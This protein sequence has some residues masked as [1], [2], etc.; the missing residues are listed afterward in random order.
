MKLPTALAQAIARQAEK[1]DPKELARAVEE[2]SRRYRATTGYT[3]PLHTAIEQAAYLVTRMPATFAACSAVF[4][5]L[6]NRLR[7]TA[8]LSMLDL[9]AGPGTAV[10]AAFEIFPGLRSI[11]LVE[12]EPG[13]AETGLALGTSALMKAKWTCADLNHYRPSED[14]DLVTLAYSLGE[15]AERERPALIAGAWRSARMAL[16]IIE[17]GTPRGYAVAIEARDQL[18]AAGAHLLAPC[19]HQ[20]RC[21]MQGTKDWCH[22]AARLE[23]SSTHRKLKS[24]S[25]GYEDEKFAYVIFGRSPAPPAE[26]RIVRHPIHGKGHIKLE[27]CAQDGLKQV[28]VARSQAEAFRRA[29]KAAWGDGWPLS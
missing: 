5:E 2:L 9:G 17:P 22:F 6:R 14:F 8:P 18:I 21:P 10:W 27:L 11:E 3:K 29:R 1:F 4:R 19:P 7:S 13:M 23:R 16:A 12:R 26:T 15:I 20:R 25:L 24:A 28:T